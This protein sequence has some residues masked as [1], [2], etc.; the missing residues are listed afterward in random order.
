MC[1]I[2]RNTVPQNKVLYFISVFVFDRYLATMAQE[3]ELRQLDSVFR[4][5]AI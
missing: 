1:H 3:I 5:F 2:K 4:Q